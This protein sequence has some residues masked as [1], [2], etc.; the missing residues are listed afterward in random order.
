MRKSLRITRRPRR[1]WQDTNELNRR[2]GCAAKL[3]SSDVQSI[4]LKVPLG[5]A[6]VEKEKADLAEGEAKLQCS[7]MEG[8]CQHH[9][10]L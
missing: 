5:L 2:V 10:G 6:P 1:V 8:L 4:Y 7:P 3:R 9:R